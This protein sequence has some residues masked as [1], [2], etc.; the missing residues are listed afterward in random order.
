MADGFQAGSQRLH[1]R[2]IRSQEQ[3]LTPQVTGVSFVK[4]HRCYCI[5]LQRRHID[6]FGFWK[7]P[8]QIAGEM[9]ASEWN[10]GNPVEMVRYKWLRA[11]SSKRLR[12]ARKRCWN[13]GACSPASVLRLTHRSSNGVRR[14]KGS[15]GSSREGP[16]FFQYRRPFFG[17]RRHRLLQHGDRRVWPMDAKIKHDAASMP[18]T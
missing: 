3:D 13:G 17:L 1:A 2:R 18:S 5:L 8:Q 7:L 9:L 16:G 12:A 6:G 4:Q 15:A 11:S 10:L 14:C